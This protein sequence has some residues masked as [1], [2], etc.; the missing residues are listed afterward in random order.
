M[1]YTELS[2][3]DLLERITESDTDALA[4]LYDRYG[5]RVFALAAR[6]LN[7][8]ISSEEITQDVFLSIW[9]KGSELQRGQR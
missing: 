8:P 1:N 4:A 7:D 3:L 9:A 2:D 5:R 6:I